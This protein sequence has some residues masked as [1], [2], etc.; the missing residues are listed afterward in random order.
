MTPQQIADAVAKRRQTQAANLAAGTSVR[1]QRAAKAAAKAGQPFVAPTPRPV[2]PNPFGR[3]RRRRFV[4]PNVPPVTVKTGPVF[5]TPKPS[6]RALKLAAMVALEAAM[7]AK[8]EDAGG[9][10]TLTDDTRHSFARYKKIK[11]LALGVTP[12]ATPETR[13]EADS[14]LRLATLELV[15]LA[16]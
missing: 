10:A 1:Q 5:A 9:L 11:A 3:R 2:V 6:Y 15:K 4:N 16:Y 7:V 8:L 14:A 13:V 12:T